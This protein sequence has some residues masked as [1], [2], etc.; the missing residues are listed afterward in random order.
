MVMLFRVGFSKHPKR[1]TRNAR[2]TPNP[3]CACNMSRTRVLRRSL[4]LCIAILLEDWAV[5][6]S[7]MVS[8]KKVEDILNDSIIPYWR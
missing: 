4:A 3:C 5:V 8:V 6:D 7:N 1:G 2:N